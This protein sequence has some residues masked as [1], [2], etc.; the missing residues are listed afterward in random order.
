MCVCVTGCGGCSPLVGVD[1]GGQEGKVPGR[2]WSSVLEGW[3]PGREDSWPLVVVGVEGGDRD[4]RIWSL[5]EEK[6]GGV[7]N[8]PG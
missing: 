2:L 5:W 1:G 3:G 6:G 4:I 8:R 7:V